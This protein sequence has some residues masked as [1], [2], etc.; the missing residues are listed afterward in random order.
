MT[1]GAS[2]GAASSAV[3][4]ALPLPSKTS[5]GIAGG[6]GGVTTA[7]CWSTGDVDPAGARD[8]RGGDGS[9][10]RWVCPSRVGLD[11]RFPAWFLSLEV[12]KGELGPG[13]MLS[14]V[15][16]AGCTSQ[17]GAHRAFLLRL[18]SPESK[19]SLGWKPGLS[20]SP[21]EEKAGWQSPFSTDPSSAGPLPVVPG[22][23]A[24]EGTVL[25]PQPRSPAWTGTPACLST[26]ES[27][28]L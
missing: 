25:K 11:S 17:S 10:Q 22:P 23:A 7:R 20:I 5:P 6:E 1:G 24:A 9:G 26:A 18:P 21:A 16:G 27:S 15:G 28:M 13:G 12:P 14:H 8:A 2:T 19:G 4:I 3:S